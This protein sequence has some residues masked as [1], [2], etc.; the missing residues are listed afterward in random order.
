MISL[1]KIFKLRSPQPSHGC[2][3]L[4]SRADEGFNRK[5]FPLKEFVRSA[6]LVIDK[7]N[8]WWQL[9]LSLKRFMSLL[10][11][12]IGAIKETWSGNGTGSAV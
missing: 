11:L 6:K 7:S 9:Q 5:Y 4:K 2:E 10:K 12:D 3:K 8:T 1:K